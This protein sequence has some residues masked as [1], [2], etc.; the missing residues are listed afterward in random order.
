MQAQL[1]RDENGHESPVALGVST[2]S[3]HVNDVA[4]EQAAQQQGCE[5]QD[6]GA[7]RQR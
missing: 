1:A 2:L 7:A 4:W 3:T 5:A 6:A